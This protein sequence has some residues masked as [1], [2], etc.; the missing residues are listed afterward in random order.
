MTACTAAC[1]LSRIPAGGS[2]NVLIERKRRTITVGNLN[3]LPMNRFIAEASISCPSEEKRSKSSMARIMPHH[4]AF[5]KRNKSQSRL[6]PSRP[7][8]RR[9]GCHVEVRKRS[10]RLDLSFGLFLELAFSAKTLAVVLRD[11]VRRGAASFATSISP[12]GPVNNPNSGLFE[13]GQLHA[14]D[15]LFQGPN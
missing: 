15:L 13:I 5:R 11:L 7:H 14:A 1:V 9:D 3:R 12:A 2:A 8:S 4:S 6:L 10:E